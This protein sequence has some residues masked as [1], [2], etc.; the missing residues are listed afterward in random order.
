MP[1]DHETFWQFD[2]YAV[3]G[4]SSRRAFPRLTYGALKSRGKTVYAV[5]PEA[6]TIEGDPAYADLASLPDKVDAV[7]VEVPREDTEAWVDQVVK[8][9]IKDLWLHMNTDTP[10]AVALAKEHGIRVRTGTCAVMYVSRGFSF[11]AIHG[12]VNKLLGKY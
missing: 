6:K 5:D 1:S 7:V 4:R 8:A 12:F 2:R 11:H 10:A 3:V 9:G